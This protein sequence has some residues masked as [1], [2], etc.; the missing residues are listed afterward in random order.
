MNSRFDINTILGFLLIGGILFY[1]GYL[2]APEPTADPAAQEQTSDSASGQAAPKEE[3]PQAGAAQKATSNAPK[4]DSTQA[5]AQKPADT[6]QQIPEKTYRLENELLEVVVAN[7]GGQVVYARLKNYETFRGEPLRLIDSSAQMDLVLPGAG[8]TNLTEQRFTARQPSS[9]SLVMRYTLPTGGEVAYHY[10]LDTNSYQLQ[11]SIET[12]GVDMA[13]ALETPSLT[14]QQKALRHEKNGDMEDRQTVIEYRYLQ[15][16]D[17]DDLSGTGQEEEK[18]EEPLKWIAFKQQFFSSIL[19]ADQGGFQQVDLLM[20]PIGDTLHSK[21]MAAHLELPTDAGQL[22]IPLSLYLGPNK[23]ERLVAYGQQY[24]QLIPLGWGIFGWINR[25]IVINVFNW[26]ENYGLNY[27][28][29]I[30]IIALI[31]K[32]ILFPLTY[33]S[34]RSMAKMRV[35][36]PEIDELNEKYK[37]KDQMQKQQATMDLYRKAG[38]NPIGGCLPML[39]QLPILIALFRFFPASIE[40]RQQSFLWAD[41]L[42]TY[43]SILS[44]PFTIP[45]YGDHVS[46]FTLLMTVSTLIYTYMNQQLTGSAQNQQFPQM[47]YIIYFMPLIF[48]GVFNN[49]AAGLSYYYF[50]ANVITFGQQ[51]AIRS[52]LDDKKIHAKIEEKKKKPKKESKLMQRMKEAQQQQNRKARRQQ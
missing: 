39:L 35:L 24:E 7:T 20:N 31:F 4:T 9:R 18:L 29:I 16:E 6:G 2:N 51:F 50:V 43:D 37:D 25:G 14:W 33:Q 15:D 48:L 10:Q 26:L 8:N 52:F 28:L 22:D 49:Y 5:L 32:L 34:Y 17:V 47:K 38:V 3:A 42:S 27:G 41:D 30:L 36:K 44:L 1:F 45:F 21:F 12:R 46:L 40:L 13:S 19:T 23:Y 11:W